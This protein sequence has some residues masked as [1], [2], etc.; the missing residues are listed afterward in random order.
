MLAYLETDLVSNLKEAKTVSIAIALIN[1]YGFNIIESNLPENCTRRYL[2]GINL[3]TPPNI[4]H[5]FLTLQSN[6]P[7]EIAAKIYKASE[8]YHPK[9]YLIE[10]QDGK[11]IAFV[12][13]ANAT[14]GGFTHNIEMSFAITGQEDCIKLKAW[15]NDLFNSTGNYDDEYIS[16]YEIVYKKNQILASTQKS[17]VDKVNN[18]D[19]S[20]PGA[21]LVINPDQFFRQSDFDAFAEIRQNDSSSTAVESRAKV[22]ER[23]I[24]LAEMIAPLFSVY[25][26]TDLH[27][28]YL[29]S[30]Y[31]SKHYHAARS[32]GPKEAIWLNF[33]K[34]PA[35]LVK[36]E[37]KS[38]RKITSHQRIQVIL[39]NTNEK[40]YIGIWL[41]LS[42]S[43][44]SYFDRV[45]LKEGL[46]DRDFVERLYE[47][48]IALGGMYW[49]YIGG[50]EDLSVSKIVN[51]QQVVD[52]F[53]Q[54]NYRPE[55]IIGRN[56]SPNDKLLSEENISETILMEFSK[57]YKIYDL[58]RAPMPLPSNNNI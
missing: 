51:V 38:D 17:N 44:S 33:G 29:R 41:Y 48:V 42:R 13:S 5:R 52:F 43:N 24:K 21:G 55:I 32:N 23:L 1:E 34:S 25:N 56:Y 11:L 26:I 27:L 22:R 2:V 50:F 57:L 10:K 15:F 3:P 36:Y 6:F 9:V 46:K 39:R 35:E 45:R 58:I 47:Y 14:K 4:L 54:D 7:S 8:N 19:T 28:P 49:L 40:A 30:W 20:L 31:T 18:S 16:R 53:N 37:K 12:G